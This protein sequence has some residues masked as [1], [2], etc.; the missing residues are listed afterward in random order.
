[1]LV[2][3]LSSA[4]VWADFVNYNDGSFDLYADLAAEIG[5]VVESLP[6]AS[7]FDTNEAAA[8]VAGK[9]TCSLCAAASAELLVAQ[10]KI[11]Q[12]TAAVQH[13]D[14]KV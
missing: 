8:P 4:A 6:M 13:K 5:V 14:S 2:R 12:L 7:A 10:A 11:T 3:T 9:R 1:M